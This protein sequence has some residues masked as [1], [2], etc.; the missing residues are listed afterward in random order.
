MKGRFIIIFWVP[1]CAICLGAI[2]LALLKFCSRCML[3]FCWCLLLKLG[4]TTVQLYGRATQNY[5]DGYTRDAAACISG[6]L[7]GGTTGMILVC[8]MVGYGQQF[9]IA[10]RLLDPAIACLIQVKPML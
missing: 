7:L 8:F 2:Y 6:S 1:F 10:S 9:S 5:A 4:F 3:L